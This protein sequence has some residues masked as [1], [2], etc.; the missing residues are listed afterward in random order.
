MD[1]DTARQLLEK[2]LARSSG[3]RA[4]EEAKREGEIEPGVFAELSSMDQHQADA[5]TETFEQE[6]TA[7]VLAMEDGRLADVRHALRRLEAGTYGTCETCGT[8]IPDERLEAA[9]AARFCVTH[10]RAWELRELDLSVPVLTGGEREQTLPVSLEGLPDDDELEASVDLSAEESAMHIEREPNGMM[11]EEVEL[12]EAAE[13][14][15]RLD[16]EE[17]AARER[18]EAQAGIEEALGEE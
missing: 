3:V 7:T 13:A 8:P 12:F 15:A 4:A 6:L 5:G 18:R 16:E 11:P 14:G 2:E 1:K 10:E 9:P 17:V